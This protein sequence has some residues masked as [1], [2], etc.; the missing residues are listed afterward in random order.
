MAEEYSRSIAR[1][2]AGLLAENAGFD[3]AQE[4]AIEIMSELLLRYVSE[5]CTASKLN[6]ELAGRT[7]FNVCDVLMSLEDVGTSTSDLQVYLKSLLRAADGDLGFPH[8]LPRYPIRRECKSKPTFL[9]KKETPPPHIP[10][11]LPAFPDQHT[12]VHTPV[13]GTHSL[14]QSKQRQTEQQARRGAEQALITLHQRLTAKPGDPSDQDSSSQNPF[15][16][17]PLFET[18]SHSTNTVS[19]DNAATGHA[20]RLKASVLFDPA[21]ASRIFEQ[22]AKSGRD[23]GNAAEVSPDAVVEHDHISAVAAEKLAEQDGGNSG[24]H[25][26]TW[27]D[28]QLG[29]SSNAVKGPP[30]P[31]AAS[32]TINWT[33]RTQAL[34]AAQAS[35]RPLPDAFKEEVR[36]ALTGRKR[37]PKNEG[38]HAE[39]RRAEQILAAGA[40]AIDQAGSLLQ[41]QD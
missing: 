16:A 22:A 38:E 33:A 25:D 14:D 39:K 31:L 11:F 12:Y 18:F 35:C 24:W 30:E 15:L 37:K 40:N 29:S 34:A 20:M 7:E 3:F 4:S 13:H 10:A 5:V 8:P 2:A 27:D 41:D 26:M 23:A 9:D 19:L 17:P 36:T 6:A 32:L 28:K 21:P 1:V